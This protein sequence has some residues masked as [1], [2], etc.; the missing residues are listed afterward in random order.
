MKSAGRPATN[1]WNDINKKASL[2]WRNAAGHPCIILKRCC[3]KSEMR[4]WN[5]G[6]DIPVGGPRKLR[7]YLKREVPKV[8]WPA[9]SSIGDLLRREGLAH[10]RRRRNGRRPTP[11]R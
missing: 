2:G 5:C 4:W 11:S 7:A 10:P 8:R 1:G 9:A 3:R 6:L